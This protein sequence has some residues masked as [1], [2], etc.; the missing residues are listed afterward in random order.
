MNHYEIRFY[1]ISRYDSD[2]NPHLNQIFE[3]DRAGAIHAGEFKNIIII[4]LFQNA[5]ESGADY[6]R[7]VASVYR[8]GKLVF[9][10]SGLAFMDGSRI[11]LITHI[12]RDSQVFEYRVM[13]IAS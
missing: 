8:N 5:C 12:V 6:P 13:N 7:H 9:G 4:T 2:R 11:D 1:Q 3:F 10:V